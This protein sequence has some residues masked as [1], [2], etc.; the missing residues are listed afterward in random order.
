MITRLSTALSALLL[1]LCFSRQPMALAQQPQLSQLS[2]NRPQV[3]EQFHQHVNMLNELSERRLGNTFFTN[4]QSIFYGAQV[5]FVNAGTGNLTFARRDLVTVGRMPI[6]MARVYDSSL[7]GTGM[8]SDIESD[9]GP[10]WQLSLAQTIKVMDN[11]TLLYRDDSAVLNTFVPAT[12]GYKINP[13]QNSDITFIGFNNQGLIQ[14]DYLTGWRKHFQKLGSK[15]RL[16]KIVDNNANQLSLVYSDN[17]LSSITAANHRAVMI[18]RDE[19]GR[20]VKITDD[21]SRSVRYQ[22]DK[23]QLVSVNDLADNH[24]QYQYYGNQLL[25][26]V[27]DPLGQKA[28]TFKFGKNHKAKVVKIRAQKHRYKYRRKTTRITDENDNIT[29]LVQNDKGITTSITNAEGFTSSIVLN[30]SHQITELWHNGQ[31]QAHITYDDRGR[32][33]QYDINGKPTALEQLTQ[34]RYQQFSYQYDS[35]GRVV[36]IGDNDK[37]HIRYG[38]DGRG[39]LIL[40][41]QADFTRAYQY[42]ANGDV[43]GE[44]ETLSGQAPVKTSFSYSNDGLLTSLSKLNKTTHFAYNTVGKLNN[45]TFP[46]GQNHQ[47]AY[48][49]LGFRRQTKRSDNSQ[50]NYFYNSL[51]N[52]KKSIKTAVNQDTIT[53]NHNLNAQNQLVASQTTGHE[54]LTVKYSAKGQPQSTTR[55]NKT[56]TYQ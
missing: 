12:V 5:G 30:D 25:H 45:V 29:T 16:V 20:I 43:I 51:G 1:C 50:V 28:A 11:G 26:H 53:E 6:V 14:I 48:D 46:D 33:S 9:F 17:R 13:A 54:A 8:A 27:I 31:Q 52:L 10:G 18:S 19:T 55:G 24:W 40:H 2:Q 7:I 34:D 47:Y 56:S 44:T 49:D 21:I 41:Q 37:T 35:S 22:Y 32:P 4:E 3:S 15:Y 36:A 42:S 39:N 38:Y 23:N